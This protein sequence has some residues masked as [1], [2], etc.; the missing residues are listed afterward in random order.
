MKTDPA[1]LIFAGSITATVSGL[2]LLGVWLQLRNAQALLWWFAANI[3]YAGGLTVLAAA[4]SSGNPQLIL[5]GTAIGEIAAPLFWIGTAV[6]RQQQPPRAPIWLAIGAWV[7]LDAAGMIVLHR[8]LVG[9]AGWVF[10]LLLAALEMWRGRDERILAR[11]PLMVLF[12]IHAAVYAGGVYDILTND[13]ADPFGGWF[14]VILFEGIIYLMVSAILMALICKERETQQYKRAALSDSLTGIANHGALLE[15]AERLFARCRKD[16]APLSLIMFDL[17]HF[18]NI[19]DRHGHRAGDHIL[20]A[21]TDTVRGLL[22]PTDLIGR[23]GGE[24]FTVVLPGATIETAQV[25]AER[26]RH[27]FAEKHRQLDGRP[28]NATVSAGIAEADAEMSL[29][30]TIDAADRAMYQAKQMGRDRVERAG[31]SLS[32]NERGT[33]ARIA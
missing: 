24:E 18:K 6:F 25:I 7:A 12:L 27:A 17:D 5:A 13:S 21:F 20:R 19:N 1:T 14:G 26:V 9:L 31:R 29:E 10:W 4:V 15:N 16:G 30:D 3:V 32:A 22:R 28:L 11:W 33:V 8:P 2:V 23:Y